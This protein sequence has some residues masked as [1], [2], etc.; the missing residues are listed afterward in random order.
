MEKYF[1]VLT[2]HELFITAL[3]SIYLH[4][5]IFF[6]NSS[7]RYISFLDYSSNMNKVSWLNKL[8]QAKKI[9]E[10]TLSERTGSFWC[11][12]TWAAMDIE[13]LTF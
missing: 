7:R 3:Y 2:E 6:V 4:F 5:P 1:I 10:T 8:S 12:N 13:R 11:Y 9:R